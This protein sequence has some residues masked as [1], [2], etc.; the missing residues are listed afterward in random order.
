[1][2]V[3]TDHQIEAVT[4]TATAVHDQ[5]SPGVRIRYGMG[6]YLSLTTAEAVGLVDALAAALVELEQGGR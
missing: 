4:P 6:L 1:M 3:S 2:H 5:L